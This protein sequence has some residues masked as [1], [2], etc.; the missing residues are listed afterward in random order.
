MKYTI[1]IVDDDPDQI[2]LVSALLIASGYK[3][4]TA[5]SKAEALQILS[6]GVR[7]DVLYTDLRLEDGLGSEIL[8]EMGERVPRIVTIL[9]SGW[10]MMP[11]AKYAGFDDYLVKPATQQLLIDTINSCVSMCERKKVA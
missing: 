3:V 1:L 9:T 5:T 7:I 4:K 6:S 8:A 2:T 10:Y 11:S